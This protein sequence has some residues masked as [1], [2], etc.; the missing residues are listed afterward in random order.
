L[1]AESGGKGCVGGG[2][3]AAFDA[4]NVVVVGTV[5]LLIEPWATTSLRPK[6]SGVGA[7]VF[8]IDRL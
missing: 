3:T 7:G 2:G 5:A 6:L 8:V 1:S 4:E